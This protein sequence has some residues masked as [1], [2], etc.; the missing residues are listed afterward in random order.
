MNKDKKPSY[1]MLVVIG[2]LNHF[3]RYLG[4]DKTIHLIAEEGLT[5]QEIETLR[6]YPAVFMIETG[7]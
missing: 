7:A 4:R 1:T 3:A 5:I 2:K 6:T